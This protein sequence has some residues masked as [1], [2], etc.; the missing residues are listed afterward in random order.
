ME[1]EVNGVDCYGELHDDSNM[2]LRFEDEEYD[3]VWITRDPEVLVNWN[4]IT[5]YWNN[6]AKKHNTELWEIETDN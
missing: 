5:T 2:E 3:F 6:Y 1:I 4:D